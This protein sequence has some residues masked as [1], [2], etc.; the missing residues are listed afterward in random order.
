MQ[1]WV[2]RLTEDGVVFYPPEGR[3]AA[4]LQIRERI[5]PVR[6]L[7]DIRARHLASLGEGQNVTISDVKRLITA[8]GEYGITYQLQ[9]EAPPDKLQLAV[10]LVYGDDFYSSFE[11]T[12]TVPELGEQLIQTIEYLVHDT[13]FAL[14]FMRR[15][16]YGYHAP[17][18]WQPHV[19]AH[20]VSWYPLDFPK[21][22]AVIR[23]FDAV[24]AKESNSIVLARRLFDDPQNDLASVT[25]SNLFELIT[26]NSLAGVIEVTR[27]NWS[28]GVPS[29]MMRVTVQDGQYAYNLRLECSEPHIESSRALFETLV[30]SIEPLPT[31]ET[32]QGGE[33]GRL[34]HWAE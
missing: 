30:R 5:R 4:I 3:K 12:S 8:E 14:G 19:K 20:V 7:R 11:G 24:P 21:H 27:G 1:N 32:T 26:D 31:P 29:A 18:G 17:E 22:R 33:K 25:D 2:R 13:P 34:I 10:G 6:R 15:R 28:D 9:A 16:R 23:V